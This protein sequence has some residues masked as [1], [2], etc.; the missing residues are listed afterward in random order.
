MSNYSWVIHY[1]SGVVSCEQCGR[2]E[3]SLRSKM[4]DAHTHGLDEFGS[5]ELQVVVAMPPDVVGW[6]LN[7]V[8]EMVK[9]GLVLEDGMS[10]SGLLANDAELRVFKTTAYDG[11][12]VFRL[13]VPDERFQF[14]PESRQ[15]PY[16]AQ[17]ESPYL[18]NKR[19]MS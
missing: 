17:Y 14:P 9:D 16:S 3:D 10:I 2:K 11:T 13:I 4:C 6:I 18:N 1:V 7:S 12:P 19:R 8:G 15:Y 5:L